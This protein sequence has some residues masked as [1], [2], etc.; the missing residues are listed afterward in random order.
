MHVAWLNHVS[1]FGHVSW[2]GHVSWFG[3]VSILGVFLGIINAVYHQ[4]PKIKHL[5]YNSGDEGYCGGIGMFGI[6]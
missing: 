2:R 1:R 6:F 4:Y 3:N 5:I